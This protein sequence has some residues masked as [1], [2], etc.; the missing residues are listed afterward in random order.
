MAMKYVKAERVSSDD[1]WP[2]DEEGQPMTILSGKDF[3]PAPQ[4]FPSPVDTKGGSSEPRT[5]PSVPKPS[6]PRFPP[7]GG[8]TGSATEGSAYESDWRE[9]W[10]TRGWEWG[11]S[12]K[13]K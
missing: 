7:Q 9:G 2:L 11:S 13:G 3:E 6:P 4:A 5:L 8:D 12:W 10:S 1:F